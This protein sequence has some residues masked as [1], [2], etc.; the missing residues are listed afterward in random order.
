MNRPN[1]PSTDAI[2]RFAFTNA[3]HPFMTDKIEDQVG[4]RMMAG[5]PRPPRRHYV[6]KSEA[7][8]KTL[9]TPVDDAVMACLPAHRSDIS[10]GTGLSRGAIGYS[11]AKLQRMGLIEASGHSNRP[12]YRATAKSVDA[13]LAEMNGPKAIPLEERAGR[14]AA[15]RAEGHTLAAIAATIG[16]SISAVKRD[17]RRCSGV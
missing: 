3:A 7:V 10:D 6:R 2:I 5:R 12:L 13:A 8:G 17:I 4:R 11:L 15:M 16:V 1:T 9:F 14:V